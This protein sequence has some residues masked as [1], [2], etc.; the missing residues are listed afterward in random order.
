MVDTREKARRRPALFVH[1][2]RGEPF[3][4]NHLDPVLGLVREHRTETVCGIDMPT[5]CT[6]RRNNKV[7]C[8]F[9]LERMEEA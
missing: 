9:C 8:P 4:Q 1:R 5:A 3:V 7:T 2:R 6:T